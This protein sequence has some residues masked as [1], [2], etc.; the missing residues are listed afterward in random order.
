[1]SR[2]SSVLA[3]AR[4]VRLA[5]P[6]ALLG[7]CGMTRALEGG[8]PVV[9]IETA[10]GT[11]LG[12]N[13]DLGVLFM[14]RTRS[15]GHCKVTVFFGGTPVVENSTIET[16]H[17]GLCQARLQIQSPAAPKRTRISAPTSTGCRWMTR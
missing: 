9:R 4:L 7:G 3:C 11:E 6:A 2:T 10:G 16:I 14:G 12:V 8:P 13:T 1:V 17:G 5:L 15:A